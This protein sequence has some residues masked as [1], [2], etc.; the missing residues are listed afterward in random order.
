MERRWRN[1]LHAKELSHSGTEFA[2]QGE[3]V[4]GGTLF[5]C[6]IP[7]VSMK[8]ENVNDEEWGRGGETGM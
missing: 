1:Y 3:L 6:R 5:K 4:H 8:Q 2:Y 7:S